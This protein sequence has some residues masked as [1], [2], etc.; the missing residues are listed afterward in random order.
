MSNEKIKYKRPI[1]EEYFLQI[2]EDVGK[3]G[4]CDRGRSGAIIVK[5]NR[6]LTTGY[7][8]SPQG[9]PHCDEV[10]HLFQTVKDE[11]TGKVSKHCVRTIHAEEN[12]ILQA[13]QFGIS[14]IGSTIYCKMFPCFRC[15]M[16]IVRVGIVEVIALRDYHDSSYSK[17]IFN[18]AEIKY[19]IIENK[20]E[21]Y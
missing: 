10:G 9:L 1:W 14:L 15:A 5:E 8:G 7:V 12:A 16:K 18:I 21:E 4:T 13:A 20:T 6:I 11:K 2:M 19:R 17:E 3:R